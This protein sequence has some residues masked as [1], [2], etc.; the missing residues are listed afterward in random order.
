MFV[1]ERAPASSPFWP[2]A[3]LVLLP[4]L[5]SSTQPA[6]NRN[7]CFG[8]LCSHRHS[9]CPK[10]EVLYPWIGLTR[11]LST[12]IF[13]PLANI[14][15]SFVTERQLPALFLKSPVMWDALSIVTNTVQSG[16]KSTNP[17][18]NIN[19]CSS[20]AELSFHGY[21]GSVCLQYPGTPQGEQTPSGW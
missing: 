14:L 7:L 20:G 1:Q 6:S 12:F 3:V 8:S 11:S 10:Q 21:E 9:L 15:Y 16:L 19:C 18:F 13:S 17:H 2:C 5:L 4:A